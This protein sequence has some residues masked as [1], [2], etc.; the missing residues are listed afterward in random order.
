MGKS[1]RGVH[2]DPFITPPEE[3]NTGPSF[4]RGSGGGARGRGF[5]NGWGHMRV[6]VPFPIAAAVCVSVCRH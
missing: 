3:T 5:E 6:L 4:N 2:G 1:M